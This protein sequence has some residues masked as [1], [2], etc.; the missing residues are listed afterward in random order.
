MYFPADNGLLSAPPR[1][2]GAGGAGAGAPWPRLTDS[3]PLHPGRGSRARAREPGARPP[4][5][6]NAHWSAL[7]RPGAPREPRRTGQSENALR[8]GPRVPGSRGP[9]PTPHPGP[10][11][12]AP[13]GRRVGVRPLPWPLPS[14]R[15]SRSGQQVQTGRARAAAAPRVPP[16]LPR[17][18]RPYSP[19]PCPQSVGPWARRRLRA[20]GMTSEEPRP[21]DSFRPE[22]GP[23]EWGPGRQRRRRG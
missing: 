18:P 19:T 17:P 7:S 9:L 5:P 15:S 22:R 14:P 13:R 12:D 8:A 20:T 6:P 10:R 4:P 21:I 16:H 23:R 1:A 3:P 2:G 11:G